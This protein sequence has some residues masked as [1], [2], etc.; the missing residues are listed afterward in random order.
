ME[1]FSPFF[2]I[3]KWLSGSS[4]RTYQIKYAVN[5]VLRN[6]QLISEEDLGAVLLEVIQHKNIRGHFESVHTDLKAVGIAGIEIGSHEVIFHK[7]IAP[8]ETS[9]DTLK[10]SLNRTNSIVANNKRLGD[11]YFDNRNFSKARMAYEKAV[12]LDPESMDS[13]AIL[14]GSAIATKSFNEV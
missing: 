9:Q 14:A 5:S 3:L 8:R 4:V 13:W 12:N 7:D 10:G 6:R 2:K 1:A 11:T